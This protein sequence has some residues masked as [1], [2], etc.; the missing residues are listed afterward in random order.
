MIMTDSAT[1]EMTAKMKNANEF[2]ET[3]KTA[4]TAISNLEK[5]SCTQAASDELANTGKALDDFYEEVLKHK[6]ESL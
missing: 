5:F 3:L 1:N 2:T 6:G 4:R